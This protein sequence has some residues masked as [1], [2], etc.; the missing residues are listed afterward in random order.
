MSRGVSMRRKL[1]LSVAYEKFSEKGY[2][3]SLS[4]IAKD[5][6]IK[7]QT[8]Y[9][10]YESKDD[11][12]FEVIRI[13]AIQ[14]FTE[15]QQQFMN[16]NSKDTR[17]KLEQIFK[18][19][20]NYF[21]DR[22]RYRFWRWLIVIDSEPLIAKCNEL[23]NEHKKDFLEILRD[24]FSTGIKNG[25]IREQSIEA[26]ID[27]FIVLVHGS[28]DAQVFYGNLIKRESFVENVWETFWNGIS[29]KS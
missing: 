6:G 28:L 14:Y 26:L 20:M 2:N 25:E 16:L 3:A 17:T 18:P 15:M 13:E 11:L 21:K 9:N 8:L 1:I 10:Y 12:Y 29:R 5:S 23:T 22:N 24:T 27:T 7:K 19:L 4:E